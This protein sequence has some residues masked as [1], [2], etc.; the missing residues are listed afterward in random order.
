MQSIEEDLN[1]SFQEPLEDDGPDA[2]SI[3]FPTENIKT[4]PQVSF[5]L[6]THKST[7]RET[8]FL[9]RCGKIYL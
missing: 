8:I 3:L 6:K 1:S 4:E 7:K 9:D 5:T 2:T